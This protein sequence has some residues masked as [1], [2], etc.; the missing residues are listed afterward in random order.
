[1]APK[2]PFSNGPD[3]NFLKNLSDAE[4]KELLSLT[5]DLVQL[6]FDLAGFVDPTPVSDAASGLISLARGQWFD[7][8]ISGVSMIPYVGDLAKAGKLPKYLKS[9]ERAVALADKSADMAKALI[10]GMKKLDHLLGM[11]PAGTNQTFDAIRR[12]VKQFLTK[13]GTAA[14]AKLTKTFPDISHTFRFRV[15]KNV[16]RPSGIYDLKIAEGKLGVPGQ[17]RT[18]RSKSAQSAVSK[19]TGDDAGHLIGDRFG[20]PTHDGNLSLQNW[21]ANQGGGTFHNLENDWEWKLKNG[22]GIEVSI[23]DMIPAGTNRPKFRKVRWKETRPDGAVVHREL[24][25]LNTHTAD[26]PHRAGSRTKQNVAPTVP[27]GNMGQLLPF[28]EGGRRN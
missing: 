7:A 21:K 15:Q 14:G 11:I 17:V 26:A 13:H 4:R 1:M 20:A 22:Y 5:T 10:P 3:A 25:F 27:E 24:D 6:A 2:P 28:P 8:A 19:G 23:M 16:R 18:H 9:V 12:E